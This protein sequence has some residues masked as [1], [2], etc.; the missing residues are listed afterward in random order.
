MHVDNR[1]VSMETCFFP[2]TLTD[3]MPA[4]YQQEKAMQSQLGAPTRCAHLLS[5]ILSSSNISHFC[6]ITGP[7]LLP[8]RTSV[9]NTHL[10]IAFSLTYYVIT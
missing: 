1:E 4:R 7:I 9:S 2:P 5:I 3:N 6:K 8:S 10:D